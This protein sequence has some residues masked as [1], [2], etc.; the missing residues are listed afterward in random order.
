MRGIER[1]SATPEAERI[2]CI[3]ARTASVDSRA[4][5]G[6]TGRLSTSLTEG[7]EGR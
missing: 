2:R 4:E 6:D 5:P 3:T 7:L 1:R